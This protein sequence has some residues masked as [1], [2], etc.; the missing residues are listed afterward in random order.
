MAEVK[1][2]KG[3]FGQAFREAEKAGDKQFR[4]YN[5]KKKKMEIFAVKHQEDPK[6]VTR[7]KLSSQ[8][9]KAE[10]DYKSGK[11]NSKQLTVKKRKNGDLDA[12]NLGDVSVTAAYTKLSRKT[13][14]FQPI[15]KRTDMVDAQGNTRL[16]KNR[17]T[18]QY[19]I[20]DND[21]YIRYKTTDSNIEN[22]GFWQVQ[23]A[24]GSVEDIK[25]RG[26][27]ALASR[28]NL[29]EVNQLIEQADLRSRGLGVTNGLYDNGDMADS[30][31]RG[32]QAIANVINQTMNIPVHA[33]WGAA[34]TAT[35]KYTWQDYIQGF[36]MN[37]F[38][39]NV[40]QTMG[41]GDI[42]GDYVTLDDGTKMIANLASNYAL[43]SIA[44]SKMPTKTTSKG[45]TYKGKAPDKHIEVSPRIS[46]NGRAVDVSRMNVHTN[47]NGYNGFTDNFWNSSAPA[48]VRTFNGKAVMMESEPMFI[49]DPKTGA[50]SVN[51]TKFNPVKNGNRSQ[52]GNL[53]MLR[54]ERGQVTSVG[55]TSS[56]QSPVAMRATYETHGIPKTTLVEK[57]VRGQT[58][59]FTEGI[60]TTE[61]VPGQFSH[62]MPWH[63]I[64]SNKKEKVNY[65]RPENPT[66]YLYDGESTNVPHMLRYGEAPAWNSTQP[67]VP[68]K[69]SNGSMWVLDSNG[70]IINRWSGPTV[71]TGG[72]DSQHYPTVETY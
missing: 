62:G 46:E 3:S 36:N 4:W 42:I 16:Y 34:R 7:T 64:V 63:S 14:G 57:P 13:P 6:T 56:T 24:D 71:G 66:T 21:G 9:Q 65:S 17:E 20:V 31:N 58:E 35:P 37:Q 19:F 49:V 41:A 32:K 11:T 38:H 45:K 44:N 18:G 12:G 61:R 27:V 55:P 8:Q 2:Y 10:N 15:D 22:N 60:T 59:F 47:V 40:G 23:K 52:R 69:S 1:E 39:N 50:V 43:G 54:T 29:N 28:A 72:Y 70:R 53:S 5:P 67:Y 25:Q 33:I 68:G 51:Q 26:S 30:I 48:K